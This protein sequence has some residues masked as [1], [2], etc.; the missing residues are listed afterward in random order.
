MGKLVDNKSI[1]T[2]YAKYNA[3]IAIGKQCV[4]I[5]GWPS[6]ILFTIALNNACPLLDVLDIGGCQ[7]SD[8]LGIAYQNQVERR[9]RWA[10]R[11][12]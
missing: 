4:E 8:G 3:D 10:N 11:E 12:K 9:C 2:C 1:S 6:V 7:G 5:W